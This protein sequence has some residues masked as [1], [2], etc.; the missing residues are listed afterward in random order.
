MIIINDT[1][2]TYGGSI[3]LVE[4]ICIYSVSV[5]ESVKIY[6]NNMSNKEIVG[7]L[8]KLGIEI[9]CF[10]TYN[11]KLLKKH[12]K[13][14]LMQGDIRIV[15][16]VLN[17]HL[18]VEKVK[19]TDKLD[20]VN[21]LYTIHPTTL[22]KGI[23]ISNSFLKS[24]VKKRYE[25]TIQ[26]MNINDVIVF[27]DQDNIEKTEAYYSTSLKKTPHIL[28]LPMICHPLDGDV[29]EKKLDKSY[30]GKIIISACRADFPYKG[31][32][33]GL[34]DDFV[35]L[36]EKYGNLKL[37]IVCSGE[38]EDVERI[39]AKIAKI[40]EVHR[41]RIYFHSWM[42]Y[43]KLLKLISISYMFVGMGTGILDS[44]LSYVPSIAVKY[45]TYENL[46]DCVLY[47]KPH[48]VVADKNCTL[49]AIN[50]MEDLL[51]CTRHEYG[52]IAVKCYEE[53]QKGY[54]MDNYFR[55]INT[56]DKKPCYLSFMD[57][58]IHTVYIFIKSLKHE[59]KYDVN[60]IEYEKGDEN[61]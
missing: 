61:S 4:R 5:N 49:G 59:K 28:A 29:L 55:Y 2:G 27:M 51:T 12:I 50:I 31:Y 7:K 46:A 6:C 15:S 47:E 3:T 35:K 33:F 30:D 52:K 38:K 25:K 24:M 22:C 20:F 40:P 18:S 17:N 16:F 43:Q 13:N 9:E 48:Y 56:L 37:V 57:V 32:L 39:R 53:A 58:A 60:N 21:I 41:D 36:N 42:E 45:N 1:L 10:D 8:N 11:H 54:A 19:Y 26:K 34:V 44:A 23:S 14:D